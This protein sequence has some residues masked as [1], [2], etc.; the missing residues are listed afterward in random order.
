MSV[1]RGRWY[2]DLTVKPDGTVQ[3]ESRVREVCNSG[4]SSLRLPEHV[5]RL[6]HAEYVH[7]YGPK[8][9][10]ERMQER[11]GLGI[12]E[13]VGLLADLAERHGAEPYPPREAR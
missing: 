9:D 13:I 6:A 8:Q 1:S 10:Y 12:L 11:M 2:G 4:R 5:L 7:Q 3:I